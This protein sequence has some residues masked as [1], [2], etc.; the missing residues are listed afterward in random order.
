[1]YRE[2]EDEQGQHPCPKCGYE[3]W[4]DPQREEEEE[5]NESISVWLVQEICSTK[6]LQEAPNY[7]HLVAETFAELNNAGGG[8]LTKTP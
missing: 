3:W 1:V 8:V 4:E 2:P 6:I 7:S 5:E